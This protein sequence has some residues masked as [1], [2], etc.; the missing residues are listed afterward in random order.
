MPAL[1]SWLRFFVA[2]QVA[3][4]VAFAQTA[5]RLL[6]PVNQTEY[7]GSPFV[8]KRPSS[9]VPTLVFQPTGSSASLDCNSTACSVVPDKAGDYVAELPLGDTI[10]LRALSLADEWPLRFTDGF[11]G[12]P[13]VDTCSDQY[14]SVYEPLF[15]DGSCGLDRDGT[16]NLLMPATGAAPRACG[17]ITARAGFGF[18]SEQLIHRWSNITVN[19]TQMEGAEETASFTVGVLP[20]TFGDVTP[21]SAAAALIAASPFGSGI[22][23]AIGTSI[24]VSSASTASVVV[25]SNSGTSCDKRF[26]HELDSSCV[27]AGVVSVEWLDMSLNYANIT[28]GISCG[29]S[30]MTWSQPHRVNW[31]AWAAGSSPPAD[32]DRVHVATAIVATG[33]WA[34]GTALRASVDGWR[35]STTLPHFV[36]PAQLT[37]ITDGAAVDS[38]FAS[39]GTA[40][41]HNE[42]VL[43]I[44]DASLAPFRA[45][46]TGVSDSTTAIN[47]AIA[48]ARY[49]SLVTYLPVGNYT[50]SDTI[51][52]VAYGRINPTTVT[53]DGT[54]VLNHGAPGRPV[55]A[56]LRGQVLL[57]D[58]SQ[59]ATLVLRSAAPGFGDASQPK[60]VVNMTNDEAAAVGAPEHMQPNEVMNVAMTAIDVVVQGGN[61]G[62]IGV[63][64]RAAQGS[65]TEDVR[66]VMRSGLFGVSGLP[67]SGGATVGLTITGGQ[68]GVDAR[69]TQPQSTVTGLTMSGQEC[70]AIVTMSGQSLT[71]V[72]AVITRN[73]SS[74]GMLGGIPTILQACDTAAAVGDAGGAC[75]TPAAFDYCADPAEAYSGQLV[76]KD[77]VITATSAALQSSTAAAGAAAGAAEE[78]MAPLLS[79]PP[80]AVA[81]WTQ[82][83][84]VFEEV[85]VSGHSAVLRATS[86]DAG[87]QWPVNLTVPAAVAPATTRVLDFVVVPVTPPVLDWNRAKDPSE[88]LNYTFPAT[89]LSAS[90]AG[91]WNRSHSPVLQ[92]HDTADAPPPDL[93]ARHLWAGGFPGFE[94]PGAVLAKL[95]G[96]AGRPAAAGDGIA[97]DF[98]AIQQALQEACPSGGGGGVVVL[99]RGVF[100]L[101]QGLEV[102]A[103]CALVGSSSPFTHLVMLPNATA[104]P[105]S[106]AGG[107]LRWILT[108]TAG[109]RPVAGVQLPTT[110]A[111]LQVR[112]WGSIADTTSAV[113]VLVP[114]N[115]PPPAPGVP[116]PTGFQ[117]RQAA[118]WRKDL[119]GGWWTTPQGSPC[120]AGQ[121]SQWPMLQITDAPSSTRGT[122]GTWR[123]ALYM[124]HFEDSTSEAA[125]YRHV[126]VSQLGSHLVE[127]YH[128]N[129]EHAESD[130]NT[131]IADTSATVRIYGLKSEGRYAALWVHSLRPGADVTLYG[132][133]GNAC[134]FPATSSYPAGFLQVPP[135]LMRVG[136]GLA[137]PVS[138]T[139]S[140]LRRV[141]PASARVRLL[142]LMGFEM[143]GTLSQDRKWGGDVECAKPALT[144]DVLLMSGNT[145]TLPTEPLERAASVTIIVQ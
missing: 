71:L 130:A 145:T 72:G 46:P 92:L 139:T 22:G 134:P 96:P 141:G 118:S 51:Q 100:A 133:G 116:A 35:V 77:S 119:C 61:P 58:P 69:G 40:Q 33:Q 10:V 30:S 24:V 114:D 94:W 54:G 120:P 21:S 32:G 11:Q 132:Y 86:Q 31:A 8:F 90:Q 55:P 18:S 12:C 125:T 5:F 136:T 16:L 39:L 23:E 53:L 101:S 48:W 107:G 122:G 83:T 127:F 14:D 7:T 128:L 80:S 13:V 104:T 41:R 75:P 102:P 131:E 103:G 93:Q 4:K 144:T 142:N 45:D 89:V 121:T 105:R 87:S 112:V 79:A 126:Q 91:P 34:T 115:A 50:I 117:Y 49:R 63:R 95:P 111:F 25:W 106:V 43:G 135:S 73:S 97:D 19:A 68:W 99:G 76:V 47:R 138:G 44:V 143:P 129:T 62:A 28:G 52:L 66:V 64:L 108:A 110:V 20:S 74:A 70:G 88:R 57:S 59:R 36:Q 109:T 137:A 15:S 81:V 9:G 42:M 37:P 38:D 82:R 124:V 2:V 67:G 27:S 17:L 60:F 56:T 3:T 98:P 26:T 65:A 113:R 1:V 78:L 84:A 140:H 29:S 85:W 123:I 6:L